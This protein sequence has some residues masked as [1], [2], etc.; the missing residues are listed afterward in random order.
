MSPLAVVSVHLGCGDTSTWP[1]SCPEYFHQYIGDVGWE[2]AIATRKYDLRTS[3]ATVPANITVD[4][5]LF[6]WAKA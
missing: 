2:V 6:S 4:I 1:Q 3:I 5:Y